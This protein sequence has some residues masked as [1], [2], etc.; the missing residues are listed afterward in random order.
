[1]IDD[2]VILFTTIMC[3]V[4]VFRAIRLDAQMPWFGDDKARPKS[5]EPAREPWDRGA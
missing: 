1:M 3:L 5:A 2:A 4:V